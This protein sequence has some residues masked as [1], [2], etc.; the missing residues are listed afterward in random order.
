MILFSNKSYLRAVNEFVELND[1]TLGRHPSVI[2]LAVLCIRCQTQTSWMSLRFGLSNDCWFYYID[3][4]LE[5]IIVSFGVLIA[6]LTH[7]PWSLCISNIEC[8]ISLKVEMNIKQIHSSILLVFET[9]FRNFLSF[10]IL[11]KKFNSTLTFFLRR[12]SCF[13]KLIYKMIGKKENLDKELKCKI[14]KR[15]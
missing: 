5:F 10:W 1:Y 7:S 14:I 6:D 11:Y 9:I 4:S 2:W 13:E 8:V 3:T 12:K 15:K